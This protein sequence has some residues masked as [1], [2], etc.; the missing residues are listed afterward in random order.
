M[1][2]TGTTNYNGTFKIFNVIGTTSFE[3]MRAFNAGE[4]SGG[5]G[6][7]SLSNLTVLAPNLTLPTPILIDETIDY[8]EGAIA[9]DGGT[10]ILTVDLPFTVTNTGIVADGSLTGTAKN[11]LINTV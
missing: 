4:P 6:T 2:I 3:I 5:A 1:T 8:D 9:S 7:M 11:V 10:N